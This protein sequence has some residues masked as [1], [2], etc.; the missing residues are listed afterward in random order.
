VPTE[1]V[2]GI[3]LLT[4]LPPEGNV[5]QYKFDP[6]AVNGI[7]VAPIQYD[8]GAPTIGA[9][10]VGLTVTVIVDLGLSPQL[11]VWLT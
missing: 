7:A 1:V 3:K 4:P 2:E 8:K 10:G 11:V 9:A 5:Y 6:V